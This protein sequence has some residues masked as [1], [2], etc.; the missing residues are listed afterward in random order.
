M[1]RSCEP[2]LTHQVLLLKLRGYSEKKEEQR[3]MLFPQGITNNMDIWRPLFAFV[4]VINAPPL[5]V[6]TGSSHFL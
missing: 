5:E 3:A 1:K 4:W 2:A 6:K